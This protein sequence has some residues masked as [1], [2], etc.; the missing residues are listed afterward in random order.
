MYVLL[1]RPSRLRL[2]HGFKTELVH[3]F[4]SFKYMFKKMMCSETNSN[5][6]KL[7]FKNV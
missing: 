3:D 6:E 4:L 1:K 7:T 2:G 5:V